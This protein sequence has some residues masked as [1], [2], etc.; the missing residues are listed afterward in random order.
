MSSC[1]DRLVKDVI[2][3]CS[4]VGNG[5]LETLVWL[6]NRSD[7]TFTFDATNPNKIT[8]ITM[9]ATTKAYQAK[10]VEK[11]FDAGH[12]IVVAENR[13]NKWSHHFL[14]Q[15]F[16]MLSTDIG[17]LDN[18]EDLVAIVERKDKTTS[19]TNT[20]GEGTFIAY[21]VK[22]GL[23]TTKDTSR[24]NA[25]SGAR[26]LEFA[27]MAGQEEPSSSYVVVIGSPATYA[28]TKAALT[29]LLTPSS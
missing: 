9:A 8:A 23:Y 6:L 24:A 27:S 7:A 4:T 17:N 18:A 15:Q 20:T 1:V 29:A 11:L 28:T 14:L 5:G 21:G 10:G 13:P 26:D 16:E 25:N 3:N 12:D 22:C 19:A 2:S